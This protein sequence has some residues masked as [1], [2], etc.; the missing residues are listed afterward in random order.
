MKINPL[1]PKYRANK[2]HTKLIDTYTKIIYI[3]EGSRSTERKL[4]NARK[5]EIIMIK[6]FTEIL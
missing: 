6:K 5:K 2:P 1:L 3:D 4:K